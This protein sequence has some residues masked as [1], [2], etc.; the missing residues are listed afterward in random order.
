MI[1]EVY[2][3][4][5]PG[6]LVVLV[7]KQDAWLL[8]SYTPYLTG[9]G[10]SG[11]ANY[12]RLRKPCGTTIALSRAIL[13]CTDEAL[14]VD[15]INRNTM[16][17]RRSNLRTSSRAQNNA[18]RCTWGTWPKGISYDESKQLFRARI[19]VNGKRIS[20]GR[21]KNLEDACAAY[22]RAAQEYHN[23]FATTSCAEDLLLC[24]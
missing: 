5:M 7:D 13:S 12:V 3:H 11:G 15:H 10:V 20:L 4:I 2:Q 24:K 17:N 22:N 23:E 6:G 19:Q 1:E 8:T 14:F 9:Y 16:D 21:Y 18:N